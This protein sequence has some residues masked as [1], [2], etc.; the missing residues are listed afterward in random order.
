MRGPRYAEEMFPMKEISEMSS[1]EKSIRHSH[2]ST[3]HLW[4]ARR[5][6][7]ISRAIN[8]AAF[9]PMLDKIE[10]IQKMKDFMIK[11]SKWENSLDHSLLEKAAE[12]ILT[13]NSGKRPKVLD[14]FAGGGSIPLESI[15]LGCETYASDYNPVAV[16]LLKCTLQY[17]QEFGI[18]NQ[19]NSVGLITEEKNR[20]REDVEL[21]GR[22]VLREAELELSKYYGQDNEIPVGYIWTKTIPCQ[23]PSCNAEIPLMRQYWL[24]KI[25]DKEISLYPYAYNK[26][27]KFKLVGTGFDK[28]PEG[29]DPAKGSVSGGVVTCV[30]CGSVVDNETNARLFREGKSGQQML[31]VVYLNKGIKGKKYRLSSALDKKVFDEGGKTNGPKQK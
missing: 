13:A 18:R 20:L 1:K 14:P 17:P 15:R 31:A 11:L 9:I 27:V 4:W 7:A 8:Y 16:L 6:L 19:E 21:W 2:I 30:I 3:I 29:F 25:R 5:P 24:A 22:W 28:I 10:E 26:H 12:D 23:N